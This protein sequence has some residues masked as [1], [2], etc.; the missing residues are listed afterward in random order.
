MAL[1]CPINANG[2]P[3]SVE[4]EILMLYRGHVEFEVKM[5]GVGKRIA[6]GS[7]PNHSN[8]GLS[9]YTEDCLRCR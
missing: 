2:Q 5:D 4:G 8:L 6:K 3:N 7:V 1:N 9:V